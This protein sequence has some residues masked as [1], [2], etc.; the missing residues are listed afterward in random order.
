MRLW[1]ALLRVMCIPNF[2]FTAQSKRRRTSRPNLAQHAEQ[3][4]PDFSHSGSTIIHRVR[5]QRKYRYFLKSTQKEDKTRSVRFSHT[6]FSYNVCLNSRRVTVA[7]T[8]FTTNIIT[9]YSCMYLSPPKLKIVSSTQCTIQTIDVPVSFS[10]SSQ[11]SPQFLQ[12]KSFLLEYLHSIL[13][14]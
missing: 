13:E 14:I 3:M 4:F 1:F 10:R 12:C 8:I 11:T 6:S 2:N 9:E 5:Q 7:F